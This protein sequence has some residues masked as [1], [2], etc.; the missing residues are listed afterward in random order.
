MNIEH[1]TSNIEHRIMDSIRLS[2]IS[3][4]CFAKLAAQSKSDSIIHHSSFVNLH[5]SSAPQWGRTAASY[6]KWMLTEQSFCWIRVRGM[7]ILRP[8]FKSGTFSPI[9]LTDG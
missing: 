5:S 2:R 3:R 8:A 4:A 1:R 9:E 6:S 7:P